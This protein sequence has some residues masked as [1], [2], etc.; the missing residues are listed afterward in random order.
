MASV[1]LQGVAKGCDGKSDAIRGIDMSRELS[2]SKAPC[3]QAQKSASTSLSWASSKGSARKDWWTRSDDRRRGAARRRAAYRR[4]VTPASAPAPDSPYAWR[5]LSA[6]LALMTI[7]S[8][9]MY[10]IAVV[11]PVVQAEFG[12]ARADASLPY[13][14]MMV[15]FGLGGIAMGRLADRF[16]VMW[17]VLIGAAGLGSG[18]VLAGQAGSLTAFA[19]LHGV[20]LGAL[21]SS[22]TFA[23]L[24]ADTSLWF[25]RRRGIAVAICASGNYMAGAI[26]PPIVQHFVETV[27]W[28]STYMGLGLFCAATMPLLALALRQRPPAAAAVQPAGAASR[29][30]SASIAAPARPF[31]LSMNHAQ[32]LLCVAGVACCVAMSMPQVHIVAYCGDLGYGAA[33]GAEMLSLMLACGIASRLVSGWICDHIGG[34]RTLVLG[35]VLQGLALLLFIPFDGLVSLYLISALFGLFQGG[36]VPSYAIIVREHFPAAE[37][38]ARVGTVLMATLFGM[39]LGGWMGG[40]VF[41]LTGSY[42]AAFV[43]GIG[44]NLLNLAIALWLLARVRGGRAVAAA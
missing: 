27:G 39:A 10:V 6:V 34:L 13:T 14:L 37:A 3:R 4:V 32:W 40:K 11:L 26:W 42:H 30:K 22:A 33:R 5:R 12:S 16:G 17:V 44:W 15:G 19:V 38:G 7:G 2:L 28:R 9:A 8:G 23:P 18:F 29:T 25:E 1:D 41:D 24:V 35:S 43:N 20:L 31:G 36:I 21:G